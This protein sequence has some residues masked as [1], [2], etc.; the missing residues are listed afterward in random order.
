MPKRRAAGIFG[1]PGCG[2]DLYD[3]RHAGDAAE[4]LKLFY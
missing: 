2:C 1:A 3:R 4:K